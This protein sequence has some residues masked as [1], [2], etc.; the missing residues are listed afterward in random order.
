MKT[1]TVALENEVSNYSAEPMARASQTMAAAMQTLRSWTKRASTR[2]TLRQ[3]SYRMLED[4]GV[5]PSEAM[6]EANKPF[7]RD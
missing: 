7:W 4:I 2:R 3:L 1:A 5:E 6:H